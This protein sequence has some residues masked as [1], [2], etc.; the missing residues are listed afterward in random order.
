LLIEKL[1]ERLEELGGNSG[2]K[3]I[4]QLVI[5]NKSLITPV[6]LLYYSKYFCLMRKFIVV[7]GFIIFL[8]LA[9]ATSVYFSSR[10]SSRPSHSSSQTTRQIER[11]SLSLTNNLKQSPSIEAT[12]IPEFVYKLPDHRFDSILAAA[13]N[14]IGSLVQANI[15]HI[16]YAKAKIDATVSVDKEKRELVVNPQDVSHFQPGLYRL[17]LTLRTLEGQVTVEQDFTWGVIAVNTNKSIYK[18]QETAKIGIGVLNDKGDTLC[19]SGLFNHV[20]ALSMAITDPQGNE[21]NFSIKDKTIID[22]GK[23]TANSVTNDADFQATYQ[24]KTSGIYQVKVTA[25]VYG[26][27]RQIEDYFKVDPTVQFDVERTSFPT[28][29]YPLAPYPVTFTVTARKDYQGNIEDVVPSFFSIEHVDDNGRIEKDGDFTKIVW[30]T[31]LTAGKAKTFSYFIN[32]PRVSPEFYLIGPIT[33]GNFTEAR[34]WQ[35]ASDA[36]NSSSGLVTYE[37]GAISATWYRTWTGSAFNAQNSMSATPADSR[38]FSEKSSPIT[39]E[40]LVAVLDNTGLTIYVFRWNGSTWTQDFTVTTN[41]VTSRKM[42]LAY[43]QV[44]G[45]ALFVYSD[46]TNTI[47]YRKRVNGSWDGASSTAGTATAPK[48]WIKMVSQKSTNSILLGYVNTSNQVGAMIWDGDTNTWNNEIQDIGHVAA[49]GNAEETFAIAWE[50]QSQA[51]MIMW[52]TASSTIEYQRFDGSSWSGD[53]TGVSGYAA[54][55]DWVTAGSDDRST[56]NDI[57]IGTMNTGATPRCDFAVWDGSSWTRY[58]ATSITCRSNADRGI[59]V[60]FEHGTGQAVWVYNSSTAT[61]QLSYLTW[62]SGGGFVT[63]GTVDGTTE[64]TP[65]SIQM[66]SDPNSVGIIVIYD[67]PDTGTPANAAVWDREW[68]GSSWSAPGAGNGGSPLLTNIQPA[69]GENDEAFGFGFDLNLETQAAYR[70]FGNLNVADGGATLPSLTAQDTPYTLTQANQTFRLRMLLY[71]PDALATATNRQY[72]LQY[73][74]PGTGTCDN[75][76]GGTPST[77]TSVPTSGGQISFNN[78]LNLNSGDNIATNS[79]DPTYQ[80][81]KIEYQDYQESNPFTNSRT[82]I[83]GGETSIWDFSLIDNTTFDRVAQTFCFRIARSNGL[84]LTITKYPQLTTAALNDVK[85]QGGTLIKGGTKV[86]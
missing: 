2:N 18:P 56:S 32:F 21:T 59:N 51:A 29:I 86:Q 55:V 81:T 33:I 34:Q 40:K 66:Y 72:N 23:C 35:I 63:H 42:D 31:K 28:R 78:N 24:T 84:V 4:I 74:D 36:I 12:K 82:N 13:S 76:T 64:T 65:L 75:P 26:R 45:D 3:R 70:W 19:M 37:D 53:T 52:A 47:K 6:G 1:G 22:S 54:N 17:S 9:T 77:W 79:A 50:T 44:S 73:V 68:D 46:A 39:G 69:S 57:A 16:A 49:S 7:F 11:V 10:D 8:T 20:D 60:A 83:I 14:K 38:W 67:R 30:N 85:V 43:E 61:T 41:V 80:G 58:T 62:T 15:V 25:V 71:Y 48:S 27:Q 5:F